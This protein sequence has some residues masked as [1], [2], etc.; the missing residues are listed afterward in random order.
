MPVINIAYMRILSNNDFLNKYKNS[1][2]MKKLSRNR[3]QV[4]YSYAFPIPDFPL[5]VRIEENAGQIVSHLHEN[6][7]ELV[8]VLSGRATH[9]VANRK[10]QLTGGDIFVIGENRMHAYSETENF[11]YCNILMDL[12]T[13]KL[14]PGDLPSRPGYQTLFVIDRQDTAPDR[15]R[16]R[17]RLNL[18]QLE[19]ASRM[20]KEIAG[21]IPARRFEAIAKFMLLVGFLC[22]CCGNEEKTEGAAIPFRLGHIVAKM[23]RHCERDFP[24]A[25][26]CRQSGMSRAVL[27]RYFGNCYGMSPL[28]Y[29]IRLRVNK[30]M[31]LLKNTNLSC[32][33]IAQDCGFTDGSYFAMH[34]KKLQGVTPTAYRK[35]WQGK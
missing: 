12:N 18:E 22:D 21:L 27:F 33:E 6:F 26:M 32:G 3:N 24:I 10:Y 2:K 11:C 7:S 19:K 5:A 34:F 17:F 8:I 4:E 13:L 16:N 28:E 31:H 14:P 1:I 25:D 35:K 15:F 30:S 9:L 23:E 20:A 29:L